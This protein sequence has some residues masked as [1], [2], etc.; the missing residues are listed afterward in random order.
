MVYSLK[1]FANGINVGTTAGKVHLGA[2]SGKLKLTSGGEST[3]IQPGAGIVGDGGV[4][5]VANTSVLPFPVSGVTNGALYFASANNALFLKSGSGWYKI[6]TV[7]QAPSITLS[8]STATITG[9]NL[10]L[11]FTYTK[12]DPDGMTPTVTLANSGIATTDVC[13][14]THTTSNNHVRAVFDGTTELSDVTITLT[15]SDGISTGVGTMTIST[16]YSTLIAESENTIMTLK[17]VGNNLQNWSPT[18]SSDSGHTVNLV[19]VQFGSQM[20]AMS[21]YST[22]GW[23]ASFGGQSL[24]K[25]YKNTTR[26][27]T[28]GSPNTSYNYGD[29]TTDFYARMP[30]LIKWSSDYWPPTSTNNIR[31]STGTPSGNANDWT[32]ECWVYTTR[33][34]QNDGSNRY[35]IDM[36]GDSNNNNAPVLY[37]D[38]SGQFTHYIGGLYGTTY[39]TNL[40]QAQ[41]HKWYHL[42]VERYG[43]TTTLYVNGSP[44]D[45]HTTSYEIDIS[46][47]SSNPM[48]I[49]YNRGAT[50]QAWTGLVSD[51][52]FTRKQA[53]YKGKFTPPTEAL[54]A[55]ANT[56]MLTCN[57]PY[58]IGLS[59]GDGTNATDILVGS[60]ANFLPFSPYQHTAPHD[61]DA[62]VGS[63]GNGGKYQIPASSDFN[64]GY[65][66]GGSTTQPIC[67][68]LWY[69]Q[70][71]PS[72]VAFTLLD[73]RNTSSNSP[74]G[75]QGIVIHRKS[76]SKLYVSYGAYGSTSVT[77][78]LSDSN[79]MVNGQWTH[80]AVTVNAAGTWN[81]Y[82]NGNSRAS[83]TTVLWHGGTGPITLNHRHDGGGHGGS[84]G[85]GQVR[86]VKGDPVYRNVFQ[87]P[88]GPLTKTGG[89]YKTTKRPN[90]GSASAA[91]NNI[92]A[93]HTKLLLNWNNYKWYDA[94]GGIPMWGEEPSNSVGMGPVTS[95]T[96]QK[97]S[98]P[99]VK[100][101]GTDE[102]IDFANGYLAKVMSGAH[103][104]ED[105]TIEGW[106]YH[107]NATVAADAN[108]FD[109][110]F[111]NLGAAGGTTNVNHDKLYI[112]HSRGNKISYY[113]GGKASGADASNSGGSAWTLDHGGS[114]FT[115]QTW[116]HIALVRKQ[117]DMVKI[118]IDG[119]PS[120]YAKHQGEIGGWGYKYLGSAGYETS[121]GYKWS[122]PWLGYLS[123]WR[124]TKGLGRY[125]F[126]PKKE[127]L[128]TTTSFQQGITC[129]ASNVKLLAATTND[130]THDASGVGATLS[131]N[132]SMT[133][134][135]FAPR[136]DMYSLLGNASGATSDAQKTVDTP[137]STS[138]YQIGTGQF[139]LECWVCIVLAGS[140][141]S[142]VSSPIISAMES[143]SSANLQLK[144]NH[145]YYSL[146]GTGSGVSFGGS[147]NTETDFR[148]K[149]HWQDYGGA[150]Y[151]Y[152]GSQKPHWRHIAISRDA[153]KIYAFVD[154][155][156]IYRATHSTN[157][158]NDRFRI[159]GNG[160]TGI[161]GY[162]SNVRFVKG[163]CLYKE[164]FTPATALMPG[165]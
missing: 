73:T 153:S 79:P 9:D 80:V 109:R 130:P 115:G 99:S 45:S 154:G 38:G 34:S 36:R 163:Q 51:M 96:Q 120:G 156:C 71:S 104:R 50:T 152:G 124:W 72:H 14:I 59:D 129:N 40:E 5:I 159:G 118:Y 107:D 150:T 31:F 147:S 20:Q 42:A 143:S 39:L 52:R 140:G 137:S 70:D 58:A 28:Y 141:F 97:F 54:T 55:T 77:D 126:E 61:K 10:T 33:M 13:T 90:N 158:A 74:S 136:G 12:V 157:I 105:I 56:A 101:N 27:G 75:A 162:I 116:H 81:L 144:Y 135:T 30:Q 146:E 133:A 11:D 110:G 128:T 145:S 4:Q 67:I 37:Q 29:G 111:F 93:S 64:F 108:G 131:V 138:N 3:L 89:T 47:S 23:S 125:P 95:T 91:N 142:N 84:T 32:M 165:I 83:S 78:F 94:S 57:K 134:S 86:I 92:T 60:N 22:G 15:V 69:W 114:A 127:T 76:D 122:G 82:V 48:V 7:N 98:T 155:N 46:A 85:L 19:G 65:L 87:V 117:G 8:S 132:N 151:D 49:G 6:A 43:T 123:Q 88:N 139:T 66:G 26:N 63:S 148:M 160:S 25:G 103:W 1:T 112:D 53:I 121:G 161:Y 68:E 119:E 41:P 35:I 149:S 113:H 18:D 62:Q 2:D 44:V 17:A 100:F 21:P 102:A 16:S 24:Y 164:A 106:A